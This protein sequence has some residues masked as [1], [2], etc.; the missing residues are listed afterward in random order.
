VRV[1]AGARELIEGHGLGKIGNMARSAKAIFLPSW[2]AIKIARRAH[3]DPI[4]ISRRW[5][6]VIYHIDVLE[7][8]PEYQAAVA[9]GKLSV[10]DAYELSG[11]S[12]T[13]QPDHRPELFA[14][15]QAGKSRSAVRKLA[16]ALRSPIFPG[17][18]RSSTPRACRSCRSPSNSIRRARWGG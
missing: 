4:E 9:D 1:E 8:E 18:S 2:V 16:Q 13:V 14:A 7:L 3:K 15:F 6:D 12:P 10:R 17:W 11:S 5:D